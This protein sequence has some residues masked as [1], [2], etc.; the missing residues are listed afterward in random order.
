M[1]QNRN[2]Y[3]VRYPYEV[4][5]N[6]AARP[7][8]DRRQQEREE[9]AYRAAL[10][11]RVREEEVKERN[12]GKEFTSRQILVLAAALF[13]AAVLLTVFIVQ[14]SGNYRLRSAV[15][16]DKKTYQ[17]LVRTNALLKD[18]LDRQTDYAAVYSYATQTLGMQAPES[19]QII[20]YQRSSGESVECRGI[21]P[22]E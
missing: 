4:Y 10:L 14:L 16:T 1:A 12:A 20:Y 8:P 9:R 2:A 19:Q 7:I 11:R 21:I 6:T 13:A 22:D 3:R 15:E 17:E 18:K 5:G